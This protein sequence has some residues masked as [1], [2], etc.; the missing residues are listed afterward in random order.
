MNKVLECYSTDKT[1]Y[2][3]PAFRE[4]YQ[5]LVDTMNLILVENI[6]FRG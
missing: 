5:N 2:K 3:G 6:V 1:T 4:A